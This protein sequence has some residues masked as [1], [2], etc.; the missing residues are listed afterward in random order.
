MH[1]FITSCSAGFFR[2]FDACTPQVSV[3]PVKEVTNKKYPLLLKYRELYG[4]I[5]CIIIILRGQVCTVE[6]IDRSI[7]P[8]IV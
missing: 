6:I 8:G 1:I 2:N 5:I 3:L 7:V 4:Y